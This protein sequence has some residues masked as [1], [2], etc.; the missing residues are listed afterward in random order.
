MAASR[1]AQ[2][3]ALYRALEHRERTRP[4]L[5]EDPFAAE[6]LR[7][8][9]RL[10]LAAARMPKVHA[11]I[12]RYAD[13]RA[14]GARTSAIAR[15]RFIDDVVRR[16]VADGVAQ[17][18]VLGA[19]FDSRAHRMTELARATVFEIDRPETQRTKTAVLGGRSPIA[20][21][22]YLPVDFLRDDLG[23]ALVAAGWESAAGTLFVWEGVTNYLTRE[24][25][26]S[27]LEWIAATLGRA[28][29]VFTYVHAGL[30]DGSVRFEGGERILANV[31]ALGEPWTFGLRPT[32]VAAFLGRH[33]LALEEDLGADDYRA[34]YLPADPNGDR[35]YS[36]YRLAVATKRGSGD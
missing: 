31:R 25:V 8:S 17:V 4:R 20:R 3:V 35:G 13:R 24:A 32:E 23:A 34:R 30:L 12:R 22:R 27:V 11:W 21:V 19:G 36:F 5:F 15:T 29:L 16:H 6:F 33:G 7:P 2:Y 1:T 14:P 10:L 18:V 9:H 26:E 28:A